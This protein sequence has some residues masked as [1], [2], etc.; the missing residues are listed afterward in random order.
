MLDIA[1]DENFLMESLKN[2][3]PPGDK[4][5]DKSNLSIN[6]PQN[7][8]QELVSEGF[9]TSGLKLKQM[10][11]PNSQE[12]IN[13]I[14]ALQDISKPIDRQSVGLPPRSKP[15]GHTSGGLPARNGHQNGTHN[16][17][18]L[19]KGSGS[20]KKGS[21]SVGKFNDSI[22]DRVAES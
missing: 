18:N 6:F 19:P 1:S 12:D 10:M 7:L 16:N 14:M 21:G 22:N 5:L 8:P 11:D 17:Q 3:K 15:G 20:I 4:S 13:E 9:V 2:F